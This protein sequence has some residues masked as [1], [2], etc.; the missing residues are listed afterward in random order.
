MEQRAGRIVR[1]GNQNKEVYILRYVTKGTFDAYMYQ[2]VENKQKFI[3]QIMTGRLSVR[4]AEDIDSAALSYAEVK[5]LA[6]DNPLIKE[7]MELDVEVS[8]LKLMKSSHFNQKYQL[9]DKIAKFYPYE[10]A[11]LEKQFSEMEQDNAYLKQNELSDSEV[12]SPMEIGDTIYDKRIEAGFAIL[13][14]CKMENYLEPVNIG[15]YRGFQMHLMFDSF[16]REYHLTLKKNHT[17]DLVLGSDA[18]GNIRRIDHK[19]SEISD[20]LEKTK[21][22]Y[23]DTKQQYQSAQEQVKISF[24]H[25]NELKSKQSRLDEVNMLLNLNEKDDAIL[26]DDEGDMEVAEDLKRKSVMER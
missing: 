25:E 7:K 1:Q 12:F 24:P 20:L 8:K 22:K 3:S 6:T 2:T 11:R 5:M 13:A 17:Y 23:L 16:K 26:H 18:L 15:N 9:E 4:S 14:A 19:L 21:E 10:I